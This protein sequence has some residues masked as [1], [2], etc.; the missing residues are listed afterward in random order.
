M[1]DKE[2]DALEADMGAETE[3]DAVPSYLQPERETDVEAELNLPLAPSS[4]TAGPPGRSQPQVH[5]FLI[6]GVLLSSSSLSFL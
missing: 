1:W 4:H 3:T 6:S 5:F 2:L